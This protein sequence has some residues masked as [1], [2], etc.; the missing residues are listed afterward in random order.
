MVSVAVDQRPLLING[1]A[2]SPTSWYLSTPDPNYVDN[3]GGDSFFPT[4]TS[5]FWPTQQG[6]WTLILDDV[7]VGGDPA[8]ALNFSMTSALGTANISTV[9]TPGTNT[10]GV[11]SITLTAGG[12]GFTDYPNVTIAGNG[13]GASAYCLISNGVVTDVFL[14]SPGTGYT[15]SVTVT[16]SGGGGTGATATATLGT[17][18]VG[19]AWQFTVSRAGVVDTLSLQVN[20]WRT[21]GGNY[22]YTA[23][24]ERIYSPSTSA[25]NTLSQ[26]K[27]LNPLLADQSVIDFVK[28]SS[29]RY[30]SCVRC[31]DGCCG[32]DGYNQNMVDAEDLKSPYLWSW[33]SPEVLSGSAL[34]EHPTGTRQIVATTIRTYAPSSSGWPSGWNVSWSSPHVYWPQQNANGIATPGWDGYGSGS[35]GGPYYVSPTDPGWLSLVH[36]ATFSVFIAGEIVTSAPHNLKAGQ[37]ISLN[38]VV[39]GSHSQSDGAGGVLTGQTPPN[40]QFLVYPTGATTAAFYWYPAIL[41]TNTDDSGLPGGLNNIAGSFSVEYVFDVPVPCSNGL[42]PYVAYAQMVG[43]LPGC[44][45][46]VTVPYAATDACIAAIAQR[47][48]DNFPMGR[49]VY[50]EYCNEIWSILQPAYYLSHMA[51]LGAWS[52]TNF[53]ESGVVRA[54]GVTRHIC[55]HVQLDRHQRKHEPWQ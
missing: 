52:A 9:F 15:G 13:T 8:T 30:P 55:R 17:V 1:T 47:I 46:W 45:I 21:V 24:N 22:P 29:S 44:N 33:S 12:S 28:T 42:L 40:G 18:L 19:Q 35:L 2:G 51:Q 36:G 25:A 11:T 10:T 26:M 48:R 4:N 50:V 20:C 7:L 3:L 54:W 41:P 14:L 53:T 31:I 43:S 27:L 34:T 16:I 6:V 38:A 23:T 49:R 5:G 39:S 32:Y 37:L